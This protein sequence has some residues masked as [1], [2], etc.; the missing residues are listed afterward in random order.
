MFKEK[1][2]KLNKNFTADPELIK[3]IH[4]MPERFYVAPKKKNS[5]LIIIIIIGILVIG[6]LAVAAFYLNEN[7]KKNRLQPMVNANSENQNANSN[8]NNPPLNENLN[9]NANLN[10]NEAANANTNETPSTTANL[11]SNANLNTNYSRP[12][13]LPTALDSDNDGLTA[14][15]ESLYGTNSA[16]ADT[17][18][19]G[20]ADGSELLNGYDPTKIA[21]SLAASNLFSAYSH[22]FY[23]IVYPVNWTVREQDPQKSEV[24]FVS[25]TGEFIEVLVI[26]N[27]ENLAS[28]D[29]YKKQFPEIDPATVTN[30]R[31]NDASGLRSPDNLSYYLMK[32]GD[33]SRVYILT[34]N[35]GSFTETNFFTTFQIMVKSFRLTP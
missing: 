19:D 35:T 29:W 16:V 22:Q 26:S 15:E 3:Q 23:S 28:I 27:S 7:L 18:G 11:N 12:Q 30:I 21:G 8:T 25:A 5:G 34:Y 20:Y 31:V 1:K 17:D 24:L 6:G 13:P 32:D 9:S 4:V 14:A 2:Q 10:T 33:N